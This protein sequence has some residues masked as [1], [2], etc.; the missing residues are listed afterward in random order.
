M[1][2]Q[3]MKRESA[4][5]QPLKLTFAKVQCANIPYPIPTPSSRSA[6]ATS[7]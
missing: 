4:I 5:V 1:K 3:S 7:E 2:V 6:K